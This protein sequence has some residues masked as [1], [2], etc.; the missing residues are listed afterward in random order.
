M[1]KVNSFKIIY[2]NLGVDYIKCN[3]SNNKF[4]DIQIDDFYFF[5]MEKDDNLNSYSKKFQTWDELTNDLITLGYPF[6]IY[7]ESYIN[8]QFTE[9]ELFEFTYSEI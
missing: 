7:F 5:L 4:F 6:V 3:L 1:V 9:E 2:D 8:S